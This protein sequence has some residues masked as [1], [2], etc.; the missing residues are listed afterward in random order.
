MGYYSNFEVIVDNGHSVD[1][2]DRELSE[3]TGYS[4]NRGELREA[5]WKNWEKDMLSFSKKHPDTLFKIAAEG[6]DRGDIWFAMFKNGETS[7]KQRAI[8]NFPELVFAGKTC[9]HSIY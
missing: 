7:Y 1:D 2:L 5:K 8:I 6:E 9:T 3:L 4:F